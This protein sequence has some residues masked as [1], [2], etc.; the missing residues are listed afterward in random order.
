M[1][2]MISD[3]HT[4]SAVYPDAVTPAAN[5]KKIDALLVNRD[6]R[7]CADLY[8]T[9][10]AGPSGQ[11]SHLLVGRI[12]ASPFGPDDFRIICPQTASTVGYARMTK[13]GW[14][15]TRYVDSI[16]YVW[17]GYAR[18]SLAAGVDAVVNGIHAA[19]GRHDS[20]RVD[21]AVF[22]RNRNHLSD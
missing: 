16:G 8:R 6:G 13:H 5:G 19:T 21:G 9:I 20:R 22:H 17:L 12:V 10:I 14:S 2:N 4:A 18:D 1:S 3:P 7:D 15:V 11:R